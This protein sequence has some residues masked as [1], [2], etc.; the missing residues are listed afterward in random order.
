MSTECTLENSDLATNNNHP[1]F[2]WP[3]DNNI[4]HP[5][6]SCN[7]TRS[8]NYLLQQQ[9]H[10]NHNQQSSD[11]SSCEEDVQ[12]SATNNLQQYQFLL[13]VDDN[14][15]SLISGETVA[16]SD[17][18][19]LIWSQ[20]L[21][22]TSE[23]AGGINTKN[24]LENNNQDAISEMSLLDG[25]STLISSKSCFDHNQL[26]NDDDDDYFHPYSNL[27]LGRQIHI[28][29]TDNINAME[30]SSHQYW[31]QGENGHQ[32]VKLP[33]HHCGILP[34]VDNSCPNDINSR[35][36]PDFNSISFGSYLSKPLMDTF[37]DFKPSLKTLNLAQHKK[38]GLQPSLTKS[39][40]TKSTCST[41]TRNGR[42]QEIP[43]EGKKR[44]SE[45]NSDIN[46]KR[47]KNETS[48]VSSPKIQVP[49]VKLAEKIT[50]LQQ[51]VSPFGKTDTASVLWETIN[52]VR[53]LQEQIQILSHAYLKSNTC[54]ERWGGF[55]RK[56]VDLRSRG[57]CL[58]PISC[59]PQIYRESNN[60]S[61]YL[62]PSYRGCLYR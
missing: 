33:R 2:W 15:T 51:I 54:K 48:A 49:K 55:D 14:N 42:T 22:S 10:A 11:S 12:N 59:T 23:T 50:A 40:G 13:G 39:R 3:Q 30:P 19:H 35:N 5:I 6:S 56:D 52:Y 58:V 31:R 45:D 46:S 61:D 60:G 43:S 29:Y 27:L 38:Q 4:H 47:Q 8:S 17:H 9:Q 53:F 26:A 28:N 18:N 41:L 44:R 32:E 62:I 1:N 25:A 20:L 37:N 7:T 36:F 34:Q 57:L 21:L 16:S 24:L